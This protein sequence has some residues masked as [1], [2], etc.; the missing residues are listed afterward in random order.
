MDFDLKLGPCTCTLRI[1]IPGSPADLH[2]DKKV[3]K[4]G[5]PWPP[6]APLTPGDALNAGC[7]DARRRLRP[8]PSAA[9]P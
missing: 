3:C 2:R 7:V 4:R 5:L 6:S 1:N 8:P 9:S